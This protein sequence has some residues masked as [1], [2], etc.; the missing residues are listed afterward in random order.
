MIA[1]VSRIEEFTQ[2]VIAGSSIRRNEGMALGTSLAMSNDKGIFVTRR[3]RFGD[4]RIDTRQGRSLLVQGAL[5][6]IEGL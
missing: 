6:A 3:H 5:E 2:A 4:E 1:S